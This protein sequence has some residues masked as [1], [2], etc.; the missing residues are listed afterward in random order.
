MVSESRKPAWDK[1]AVL[2][3]CKRKAIALLPWQISLLTNLGKRPRPRQAVSDFRGAMSGARRNGKTNV[4][5]I[6]DEIQL[7][8]LR[9]L[10]DLTHDT[11]PE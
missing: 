5:I 2:R 7:L 8:S 6:L 9:D 4:L 11:P 10:E 1:D 3:V